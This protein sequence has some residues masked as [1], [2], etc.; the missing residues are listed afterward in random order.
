MDRGL[1]IT[2]YNLPD[3][4]R[5]AYLSWLHELYIPRILRRPD[6][7]WAAHYASTDRGKLRPMLRESA[8][9]GTNAHLVRARA[10]ARDARAS[11]MHQDPQA[12]VDFG[13]GEARHSVRVRVPGSAQPVLRHA[14]RRSSGVEGVDR[15]SRSNFA[16]RARIVQRRAQVVAG[17]DKLTSRGR[18]VS[19]SSITWRW[20]H[21]FRQEKGC[22]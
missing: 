19:R 2:W 9:R 10:H 21:P 20:R 16:T 7:L 14:R 1:W 15:E 13:M 18:R 12:R 22:R 6:F 8:G 5:D 3:A 17:G 11:R 4:G